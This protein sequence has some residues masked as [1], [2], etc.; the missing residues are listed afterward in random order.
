MPLLFFRGF[1]RQPCSRYSA[2]R[3]EVSA[4]VR[5]GRNRSPRHISRRLRR[6]GAALL[7]AALLLTPLPAATA[8]SASTHLRPVL[9]SGL[10]LGLGRQSAAVG[11]ADPPAL[12]TTRTGREDGGVLLTTPAPVGPDLAGAAIYDN[13]G[14]VVWWREGAFMNLDAITFLGKPALSMWDNSE[15]GGKFIVLNSAYEQIAQYQMPGFFTDGHEF[16]VSPDGS[17]VL[18]LGFTFV[19]MDL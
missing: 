7:A 14:K 8:T 2:G 17:R 10:S 5:H 9:N 18:M 3:L 6:R 16:Q 19:T 12:T 15:L 1:F 13:D 4:L 11:L